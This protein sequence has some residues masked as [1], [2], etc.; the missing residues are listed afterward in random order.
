MTHMPMMSN[1]NNDTHAYDA[2]P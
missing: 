2:P 1:I